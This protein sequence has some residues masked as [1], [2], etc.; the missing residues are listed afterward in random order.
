MLGRGYL[1]EP[2]IYQLTD[3]DSHATCTEHTACA[4]FSCT[5]KGRSN[6][7]MDR[8]PRL[9]HS[10]RFSVP[11]EQRL[12]K[13]RPFRY[14]G[15]VRAP[16]NNRRLISAIAVKR[17]KPKAKKTKRVSMLLS[18]RNNLWQFLWNLQF[19]QK[20]PVSVCS[21]II[22]GSPSVVDYMNYL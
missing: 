19:N 8:A 20:A 15:N 9:H 13:T 5:S 7:Q 17:T 14:A 10:F 11:S 22:Y 2:L 16:K 12:N 21:T 4:S 6:M 18:H 3:N 1:Y